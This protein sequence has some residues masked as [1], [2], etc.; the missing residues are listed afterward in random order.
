MKVGLF[1]D[2]LGRKPFLDM[3][4]WCAANGIVGVEVGTGNFSSSPH[5]RLEELITSHEARTDFQAAFYERGLE[6]TT[7]NCSG[8]ILDGCRERR[9][10]SQKIFFD[11]L[12]LAEMLGL[13]TVVAM[14]GCP[15][16]AG[17]SA[18]YPNWV[19]SYWQAEY[20]Q[21]LAWQWKEAVEP[22]WCKAAKIAEDRGVRL[23]IEMHPGQVVYNPYTLQRLIDITGNVIGANLDPSHLFW[24]GMEPLRVIEAMGKSIYHVHI[25]DCWLDFD[26]MAL[27]GGLDNRLTTKRS[28]GH[29]SPGVGHGEYYWLQFIRSLKVNGYSGTLSIEYAGPS[30]NVEKGLQESVALLRRVIEAG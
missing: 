4:D 9:E 25:K 5:C 20:Q 10:K 11:T 30:E 28:W 2:S 16:E 3:L 27:N 8:N 14:S 12:N 24:Q 21:L 1:S 15:G 17:D 13:N 29:C 19:T 18:I 23:A 22:F 6:L 7:L 26:E